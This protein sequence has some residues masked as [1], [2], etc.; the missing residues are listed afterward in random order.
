MSKAAKLIKTM[1]FL[2][3]AGLC[4]ILVSRLVMPKRYEYSANWEAFRKETPHSM[5]VVFFGS[6]MVYCNVNPMVIWE[7]TGLS[8]YDMAGPSQTTA[9]TCYYV[10]EMFRTQSPS[11][12]MV[13][14]SNI[15]YG[16][17]NGVTSVKINLG[18]MPYDL[19]R[20][21]ATFDIAPTEDRMTLLFPPYAYHGR[22]KELTAD[23]VTKAVLGYQAD[24]LAG[25]TFVSKINPQSGRKERGFTQNEAEYQAN[26]R[27]FL[28]IQSLCAAHD[29]RCIF[30]VSASCADFP[31]AYL[32]RMRAD[33]TSTGAEFFNSM[34][35]F[36]EI[37]LD[38]EKDFYGVI[39]FNCY[40]AEKN[41]VY[42][43]K[44]LLSMGITPKQPYNEPE[45]WA[46][47]MA[48]YQSLK[49]A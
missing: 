8:V 37:G 30:Y 23:D 44:K 26:L 41:S 33:L 20:L 22:W 9:G 36:E 46:E 24:P 42:L 15:F 49:P 21:R 1:L 16:V 27:R 39:H 28:D 13:E 34:D 38:F 6:S 7:E 32:N 31:P 18:Y 47:K 2:S 25:Y 35:D 12:I 43:G 48:W 14:V 10:E 19:T 4:L 5:D 11:A 3:L 29:C 17:N 40:G 45:I